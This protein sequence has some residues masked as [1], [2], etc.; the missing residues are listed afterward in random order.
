MW[1]HVEIQ[2]I[3][4]KWHLGRFLIKLKFT[5]FTKG[6]SSLCCMQ[7]GDKTGSECPVVLW[8]SNL[9]SKDHI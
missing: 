5:L 7:F 4:K 8:T 6:K 2:L 9:I 1:I 3:G